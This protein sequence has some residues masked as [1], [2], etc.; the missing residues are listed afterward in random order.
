VLWQPISTKTHAW[1]SSSSSSI[2]QQQQQQ[3]QQQRG[4]GGGGCICEAEVYCVSVGRREVYYRSSTPL[5]QKR[6][7]QVFDMCTGGQWNGPSPLMSEA[8]NQ[9]CAG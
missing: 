8:Q 3:Q 2:E 7:R 1:G 4:G 6:P 5:G 9:F